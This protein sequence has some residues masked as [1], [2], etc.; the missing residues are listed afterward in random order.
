MKTIL[1]Y[2]T[3]S[4]LLSWAQAN[5]QSYA[6]D[7]S[8]IG[9]AA[10]ASV[11]GQ[12]TVTGSAGQSAA[13]DMSGGAYTMDGRF[14]GIIAAVSTPGTP[15][16]RIHLSS[17]NMVLVAWPATATGFVLEQTAAMGTGN[18]TTV[19][20][21]P[22]LVGGEIQVVMPLTPGNKFFRLRHP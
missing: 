8:K 16:L 1:F 17:S 13:K 6:V 7:S 9:S 22:S 5:A 18:W 20:N 11:G 19:A 3:F 12:Y 2:L 21:S 15:L 10:S 4:G 14:S